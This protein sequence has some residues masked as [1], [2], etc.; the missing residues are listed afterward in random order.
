MRL[1]VIAFAFFINFA[2]EDN[3]CSLKNTVCSNTEDNAVFNNQLISV[4]N[5]E[6]VQQN[7]LILAIQKQIT[8]LENMRH[9]ILTGNSNLRTS[10]LI[11]PTVAFS[12]NENKPNLMKND[13]SSISSL[14]VNSTTPTRSQSMVTNTNS[15]S[16]DSVF[17]VSRIF[18]SYIPSPR[19]AE[20][21][22]LRSLFANVQ[23]PFGYFICNK[24][25]DFSIF[26]SIDVRHPLFEATL[27]SLPLDATISSISLTRTSGGSGIHLFAT[28]SNDEFKLWWI[29]INPH[30][31]P[32]ASSS[33]RYGNNKN[34]K[35]KIRPL[36]QI[37]VRDEILPSLT[38]DSSITSHIPLYAKSK[39]RIIVG[40]NSGQVHF[41]G[42]EGDVLANSLSVGEG[43]PV[44]S[45]TTHNQQIVFAVTPSSIVPIDVGNSKEK[46]LPCSLAWPAPLIDF[47]PIAN[48]AGGTRGIAMFRNG[49]SW[50]LDVG[51]SDSACTIV[52]RFAVDDAFSSVVAASPS[53]TF[54][55]S[56]KAY[57][58][59]ISGANPS[60]HSAIVFNLTD[61]LQYPH[62]EVQSLVSGL[63]PPISNSK[64]GSKILPGVI[65]PMRSQTS[66][67]VVLG[68]DE[69]S[70]DVVVWEVNLPAPS[71]TTGNDFLSQ[72][73]IP[74]IILACIIFIYFQVKSVSFF[75]VLYFAEIKKERY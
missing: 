5:E 63:I 16:I 54:A 38:G 36:S 31:T 30:A 46:S 13:H 23:Q 47:L 33:G 68:L 24:H 58:L 59:L 25:G 66:H 14:P 27:P 43:E 62:Q 2:F 17:R 52:S 57:S 21:I 39:R 7:M 11:E 9:K 42:V 67:G 74:I 73:K 8:N 40:D 18:R 34:H 45:L 12:W 6:I 65:R 60:T 20:P 15:I 26:D 50:S 19:F 32:D 61:A 10:E 56:N 71:T 44:I 3:L 49:A 75:R 41:L 64:T 35:G 70:G 1:L 37:I 28:L 22:P 53:S 48:Q 51:R 29:G 4:L 55:V 69:V 72:Y